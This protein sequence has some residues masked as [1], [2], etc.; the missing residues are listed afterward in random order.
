MKKTT[1][2]FVIVTLICS[3]SIA[4]PKERTYNPTYKNL[5]ITGGIVPDSEFEAF[6]GMI[7]V[8]NII[9][10]RIG[11]YYSYESGKNDYS[12]S[13]LGATFGINTYAFVYAGLGLGESYKGSRYS[14]GGIRKEAAVGFTPYKFTTATIGWSRGVGMTYSIGI[15]FPLWDKRMKTYKATR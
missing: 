2:I 5:A 7:M 11:F 14:D 4:Q 3:I 12:Q 15:N 6:K 9:K 10:K 13:I 8:N 1:L